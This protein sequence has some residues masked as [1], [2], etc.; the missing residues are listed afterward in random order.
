MWSVGVLPIY[1]M[2]AISLTLSATLAD[3]SLHTTTRLMGKHPFDKNGYAHP[4]IFKGIMKGE[5]NFDS[6]DPKLIS[7]DAKDFIARLLIRDPNSRMTLSEALSHSWILL[8]RRTTRRI[9]PRVN[10]SM[11]WS[12][13]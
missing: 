6:A 12:L 3:T 13:L 11:L 10:S 9:L 4:V 2:Y 5:Y 1:C 8:N 7:E